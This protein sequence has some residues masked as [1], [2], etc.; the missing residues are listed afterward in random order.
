MGLLTIK[1][2]DFMAD[3]SW[4]IFLVKS[5]LQTLTFE[6]QTSYTFECGLL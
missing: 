1:N 2:E 3:L 6:S 5:Q 4:V